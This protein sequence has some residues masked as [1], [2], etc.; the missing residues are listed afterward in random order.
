MPPVSIILSCL[1]V[2]YIADLTGGFNP[3]V[4]TVNEDDMTAVL[5]IELSNPA[6]R[7]IIVTF[8]TVENTATG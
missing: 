3:T 8:T 1:M 7:N 5:I 4:F 6:D 2:I